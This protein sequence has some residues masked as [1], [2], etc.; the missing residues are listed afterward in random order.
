MIG[1]LK[2]LSAQSSVYGINRR[3]VRDSKANGDSKEKDVKVPAGYIKY[4]NE[5]LNSII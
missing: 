4:Q 3:R 1:S 2:K 5:L